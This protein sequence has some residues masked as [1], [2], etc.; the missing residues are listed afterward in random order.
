M[1]RTYISVP[2][3]TV[4]QFVVSAQNCGC[5]NWDR[6]FKLYCGDGIAHMLH[7]TPKPS[8]MHSRPHRRCNPNISQS[9][10]LLASGDA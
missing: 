5:L 1:H 8:N 9:S 10:I 2:W 4:S 3:H 6:Q 7:G